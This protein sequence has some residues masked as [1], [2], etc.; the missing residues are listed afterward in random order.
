MRFHSTKVRRGVYYVTEVA[1]VA[2]K[3]L[4][5]HRDTTNTP[6]AAKAIVDGMEAGKLV[7][8][9]GLGHTAPVGS[10]D[11]KKLS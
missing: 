9:P 1:E 10:I 3:P 11:V 7:Y 2:G 8:S 6:K 4:A 5:A